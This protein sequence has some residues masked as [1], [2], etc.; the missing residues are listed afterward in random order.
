METAKLTQ[1]NIDLTRSLYMPVANR[2]QILFFCIVDLQHINIMYQYSLEWF[3]VIFNNS[4][5]NT[6]KSSKCFSYSNIQ[7]HSNVR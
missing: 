4:I 2:A 7:F 3:I 5:L 6:E 1:I